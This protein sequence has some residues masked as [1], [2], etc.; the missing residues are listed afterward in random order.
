MFLLVFTVKNATTAN[1][2]MQTLQPFQPFTGI[3]PGPPTQ[4]YG[5]GGWSCCV[6]P[7]PPPGIRGP[8]VDSGCS[9]R[10]VS[11]FSRAESMC[12]LQQRSLFLPPGTAPAQSEGRGSSTPSVCI[13]LSAN[14]THDLLLNFR[15]LSIDVGVPDLAVFVPVR[16]GGEGGESYE[17]VSFQGRGDF[18]SF[19]SSPLL[20]IWAPE[21]SHGGRESGPSS[22]VVKEA[23]L[24]LTQRKSECRRGQ[25]QDKPRCCHASGD[26]LM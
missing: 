13:D 20:G 5:W 17:T 23:E 9:L 8:D 11:V 18:S 3:G 7:T 19:P 4:L 15:V 2:G 25:R 12:G 16:I 26:P 24:L 10:W 21:P 1:V 6:P 22:H 14:H